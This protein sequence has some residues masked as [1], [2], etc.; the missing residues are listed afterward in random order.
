[1]LSRHILRARADYYRLLLEVTT[2]GAWEPWL[3]YMLEAVRETARWTTRKIEDIGAL[4]QAAIA[5]VRARAPKIYSRELIDVIFSQP[6]CRIHNLVDA[7]IAQRQTAAVYLAT[8]ADIGVL[9]ALKVGRDK[10]F[11]H[12]ALTRILT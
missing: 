9:R 12:P 5:H 6:Y 4:R 7:A 2:R 11:V 3:L 10:L 8:L 1:H